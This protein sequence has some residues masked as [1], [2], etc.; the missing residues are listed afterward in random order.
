MVV[1]LRWIK[2]SVCGREGGEGGCEP[3]MDQ[4]LTGSLETHLFTHPPNRPPSCL[5]IFIAN[6]R[7]VE[8]I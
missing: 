5:S 7:V 4:K 2:N 8:Y 3:E 1:N 6:F